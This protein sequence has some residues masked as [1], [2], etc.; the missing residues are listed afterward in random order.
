MRRS[1]LVPPLLLLPLL[2][3]LPTGAQ[4]SEDERPLDP[5]LFKVPPPSS[6]LEPV[7]TFRY[8][9]PLGGGTR[10]IEIVERPEGFWRFEGTATGEPAEVV[11][12]LDPVT[13]LARYQGQVGEGF[14][15]CLPEGGRVGG[16]LVYPAYLSVEVV[17]GYRPLPERLKRDGCREVG[18]YTVVS[19]GESERVRLVPYGEIMPRV[20]DL[21][22]PV[23]TTRY[24]RDTATDD[25]ALRRD[26][27]PVAT[28]TPG[29]PRVDTGTPVRVT[30]VLEDRTGNTWHRVEVI[31]EG[32]A[33]EVAAEEPSGE[34][35]VEDG[36]MTLE[37]LEDDRGEEGP[38]AGWVRAGQVVGRITYTLE[39]LE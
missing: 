20:W 10:V 21:P 39:R 29:A 16:V 31:V 30:K 12:E 19:R 3:A 27:E 8:T 6:R 5:S 33:A 36:D 1:R 13:G 22:P 35:L 25:P 34:V 28:Y 2:V 24:P 14:D 7:G 11:L 4:Q 15:P 17:A 32:G 26:P 38:P 18:F 9:S 37:D 23:P